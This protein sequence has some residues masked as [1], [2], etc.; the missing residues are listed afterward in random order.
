LDGLRR[1]LGVAASVTDCDEEGRGLVAVC[2]G[3]F[4]PC[5][6]FSLTGALLTQSSI[7]ARMR[8]TTAGDMQVP[9]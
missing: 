4:F 5:W 8:I 1:L 7:L 3:F 2:T 6:S 9:D